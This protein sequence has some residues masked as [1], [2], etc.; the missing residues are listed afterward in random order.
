ME[1]WRQRRIEEGKRIGRTPCLH[2]AHKHV[3]N[4]PDLVHS[5]PHLH[6]DFGDCD[7]WLGEGVES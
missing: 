2:P 7:G 3:E 1:A 4:N 5:S 6:W